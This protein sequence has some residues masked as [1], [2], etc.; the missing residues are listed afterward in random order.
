MIGYETAKT[1]S[2]VNNDTVFLLE[3]ISE[4]AYLIFFYIIGMF[5]LS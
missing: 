3:N 1:V 2:V 5:L 4:K